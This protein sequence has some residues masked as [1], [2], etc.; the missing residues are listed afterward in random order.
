MNRTIK[1]R[2]QR[3]GDYEWIYGNYFYQENKHHIFIN[4]GLNIGLRFEVIPETVS[5]FT[6]LYDATKWEDLTETERDEWTLEG[7]MPS[8]WKGKE[9]YKNDIVEFNKT[10]G[11]TYVGKI[12]YKTRRVGFEVSV[13]N[14]GEFSFYTAFGDTCPDIKVIGNI[15]DNKDLLK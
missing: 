5:Q 4:M 9:I 15:H 1:F 14:V 2:A 13:S 10:S 8:Q 7:N 6:G 3:K 12:I 11:E